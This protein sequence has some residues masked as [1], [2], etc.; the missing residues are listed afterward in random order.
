MHVDGQ[1]SLLMMFKSVFPP[2]ATCGSQ[3]ALLLCLL[4]VMSAVCHHGAEHPVPAKRT[5][6][7][8]FRFFVRIPCLMDNC[9]W[10][11]DMF[12]YSSLGASA[13][14]KNEELHNKSLGAAKVLQMRGLDVVQEARLGLA[15]SG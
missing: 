8:V 11:S 4:A 3:R 1:P 15:T 5:A 13:P 6:R 2:G 10:L 14:G 12:G 9:F 7:L